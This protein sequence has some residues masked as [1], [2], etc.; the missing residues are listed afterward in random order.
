MAPNPHNPVSKD[1]ESFIEADDLE[2]VKKLYSETATSQRR[3]LSQ[4]IAEQAA[5]RGRAAIL[6]WCLDHTD[7]SACPLTTYDFY[8]YACWGASLAVWEQSAAT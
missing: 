4:F 3:A 6:S 2:A 1:M 5:Y 7:K 8:I